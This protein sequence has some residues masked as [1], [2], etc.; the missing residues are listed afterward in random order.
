MLKRFKRT[1]QITFPHH[2]TFMALLNIK[3]LMR[4]IEISVTDDFTE[5]DFELSLTPVDPKICNKKKITL[6]SLVT[7][8]EHNLK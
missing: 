3:V 2:F 1:R 4:I 6:H 5:L 7:E 8:R